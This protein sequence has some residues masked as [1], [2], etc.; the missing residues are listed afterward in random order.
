[1]AN[2]FKN[3]RTIQ[4]GPAQQDCVAGHIHGLREDEGSVQQLLRLASGELGSQVEPDR[5]EYRA[6][7]SGV[8]QVFP[9]AVTSQRHQ[10]NQS[11]QKMQRIRNDGMGLTRSLR[12]ELA[13]S[14]RDQ[15]GQ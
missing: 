12:R 1:V 13:Q 2:L 8:H 10:E 11:G 6:V 15:V 9:A 4:E 14:R 5:A 3:V 7:K